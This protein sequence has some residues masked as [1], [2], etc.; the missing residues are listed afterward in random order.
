MLKFSF[1]ALT[2][3]LLAGEAAACG[4]SK[5]AIPAQAKVPLARLLSN[6]D[7]PAAARA[8]R[9]QGLVEFTLEVGP[10]G[11]VSG[12]TITLSTGSPNLDG[13]TC[14]LMRSRARFAPATD[15]HG[16][17]VPDKVPG[18]IAWRL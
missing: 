7:Y 13:A 6:E 15:V 5:P 3:A 1:L 8:A 14:R 9:E 4:G 2:G 17:A 10:E 18:R 16:A 12:C 11:R